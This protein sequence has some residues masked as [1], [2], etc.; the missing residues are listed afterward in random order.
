VFA[1]GPSGG[2]AAAPVVNADPDNVP[3][4]ISYD[5]GGHLVIAEAGPNSVASF[6]VK[7]NGTVALTDRAATGQTATCWIVADGSAFY[8]SNA[9][10][11]TLSGYRDGGNGTLVPLGNTA[12]DAGTTDA[13][14]SADGQ[15][16]YARAGA[17][18]IVD[19]YRVNPGGSLTAIGSV[20]VPAAVAAMGI[21]A[22]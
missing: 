4:A 12:A 1:V 18:G 5:A 13:A 7:P 3:F 14:V 19:E 22:S 9:G 20:T 6:T 8:A 15:Y 11:G 2:L 17:K 10:S 21:A 16:L